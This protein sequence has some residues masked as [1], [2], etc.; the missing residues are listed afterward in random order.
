[1]QVLCDTPVRPV[2][3]T[4]LT[5][6]SC[7]V[8]CLIGL[9]GGALSTQVFGGGGEFNLVISPIHPPLGD[10]KA[11]SLC[12]LRC[13]HQAPKATPPHWEEPKI[14]RVRPMLLRPEGVV[15]KTKLMRSSSSP[16]S[17]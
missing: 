5:G 4:G 8:Q 2:R 15:L 3:R 16:C 12:P 6:V 13:A 11:L 9:T 14:V 7:E 1:L 17:S 10:I